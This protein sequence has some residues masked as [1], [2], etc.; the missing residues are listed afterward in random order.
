MLPG[1]ATPVST[2]GVLAAFML[3][4]ALQA[5]LGCVAGLRPSLA[6]V[7]RRLPAIGRGGGFAFAEKLQ[8]SV[9]FLWCLAVP[10]IH[11][12]LDIGGKQYCWKSIVV[13]ALCCHRRS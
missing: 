13:H 3:V 11:P 9:V 1:A 8:F 4:V 7:P 6:Q 2:A 5:L 10:T 12:E